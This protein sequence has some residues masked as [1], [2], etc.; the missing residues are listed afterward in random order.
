MG[1]MY[2]NSNM[3]YSCHSKPV[4]EYIL[5]NVLTF[6]VYTMKSNG[7]QYSI[8]FQKLHSFFQ[9]NYP[10]NIQHKALPLIYL[11]P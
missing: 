1:I 10:F 6:F 3:V 5:E 8:D 9:M 11:S 7:V 4:N 2:C